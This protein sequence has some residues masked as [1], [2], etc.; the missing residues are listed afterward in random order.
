MCNCNGAAG[1]NLLLEDRNHTAV[2]TEYIAETH[3]YI[4]RTTILQCK[5]KKLCDAFRR[6]HY[7]IEY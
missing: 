1:S 2:G 5:E 3:R 7:I 6:T 4:L